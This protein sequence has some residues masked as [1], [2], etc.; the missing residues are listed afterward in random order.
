MKSLVIFMLIL[1]SALLAQAQSLVI[2]EFLAG[3]SS[4]ITDNKGEYEDWIEI[5]NTSSSPYNLAGMF[6][7][8]DLAMPLKFQIP[9]GN[10]STIIPAGGYLV[11][12]ADNDT[13]QGILHLDFKLSTG[14]EQL[15]LFDGLGNP[16]DTFS[17]PAQFTNVSF[18]RNPDGS[19]N[20]VYYS[21]TTPGSTNAQNYLSVMTDSHIF[22][23]ISGES[24]DVQIES[25]QNWIITNPV[26]WLQVDPMSGSNDGNITIETIEANTTGNDRSAQITLSAAGVQDQIIEI[27]QFGEDD[28][29]NLVINEFMADNVAG[30]IDNKGEYDDWIEIYNPSSSSVDVG[31][32]YITDDLDDPTKFQIPSDYPDSTSIAPQGFLLL[33]ADKD[34]EQGILHLDFALNNSGEQVGLFVSQF[35]PIDTFSYGQQYKDTSFGR[36]SDGHYAWTYFTNPTPGM[37]NNLGIDEISYQ[38]IAVYPNPCS[39]HIYFEKTFQYQTHIKIFSSTGKMVLSKEFA[40]GANKL[41]LPLLPRGIYFLTV[42][43]DNENYHQKIIV[44]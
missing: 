26:S 27:V 34:P 12:F 3:N 31:G 9:V 40:G 32:M 44:E 14:G 37:T 22:S 25:N 39:D 19:N 35:S 13:E 33:W 2:N 43:T 36:T 11:L 24:I 17:F 5:Y 29:P 1:L 10:D 21:E 28:I 38:T 18:G 15:G 4:D 16:V 7:T 42:L 23:H 20:W 41:L 6:I 30:I 8:D